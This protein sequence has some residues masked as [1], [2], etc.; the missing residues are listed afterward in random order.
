MTANSPVPPTAP[1][2]KDARSPE[3]IVK[4]QSALVDTYSWQCCVNCEHW[5][6]HKIVKVAD[7]TKYSGF[8]EDDLGEMCTKYSMRP[9]AKVITIGCIEY[10]PMI[11]F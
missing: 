9:P 2:R 8:R 6:D 3:F 7:E 5:T 10:E 4:S 1:I 11:P